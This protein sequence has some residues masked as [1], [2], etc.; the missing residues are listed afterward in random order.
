MKDLLPKYFSSEWSPA[1][2]RIPDAR[3]LLVTFSPSSTGTDHGVK[4]G[5]NSFVVLSYDGTF[6]RFVFD[7][8]RG[9]PC[10]AEQAT[11]FLHLASFE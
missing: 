6:Y 3:S 7:P 2:A 4:S 5:S 1:H 9:G 8:Q 10:V 11:K